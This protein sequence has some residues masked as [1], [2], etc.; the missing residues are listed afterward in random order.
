MTNPVTVGNVLVV[1]PSVRLI[2]FPAKRKSFASVIEILIIQFTL[3]N[4]PE[5]MDKVV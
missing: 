3:K 1:V 4:Y 2:A 5:L